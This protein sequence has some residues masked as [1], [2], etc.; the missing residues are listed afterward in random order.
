MVLYP[1]LLSQSWSTTVPNFMLV[2]GI[3]QL[4]QY[5]AHSHLA[6]DLWSR[7]YRIWTVWSSMLKPASHTAQCLSL[8]YT[9][10]GWANGSNTVYLV[11][12]G[13]TGTS[14]ELQPCWG[15]VG[16]IETMYV[17]AKHGYTRSS[18]VCRG[19]NT[20]CK[21]IFI[22]LLYSSKYGLVQSVTAD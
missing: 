16:T 8:S 12:H 7:V 14:I 19:L 6:K 22:R 3:A 17:R 4:G 21:T 1:I 5:L 11:I 13:L 15:C 20:I 9:E 2:S 10:H 18:K